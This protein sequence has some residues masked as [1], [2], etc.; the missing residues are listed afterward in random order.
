MWGRPRNVTF[1]A[2]RGA[3]DRTHRHWPSRRPSLQ[4]EREP[5]ACT[6]C[7][8]CEQGNTHRT[9]GLSGAPSPPDTQTFSP[10]TLP[11][12]FLALRKLI[13][14]ILKISRESPGFQNTCDVVIDYYIK[15]QNTL[16]RVRTC[17]RGRTSPSRGVK[18]AMQTERNAIS[19]TA[20]EPTCAFVTGVNLLRWGFS[21]N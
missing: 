18:S 3:Q 9:A 10:S 8:T 16:T 15:P 13:F 14:E 4:M 11:P 7:P 17:L 2:L 5:R 21:K 19:A 1:C 6:V 20:M 12:T